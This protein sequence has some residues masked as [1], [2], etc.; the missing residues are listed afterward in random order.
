MYLLGQNGRD[1]F[2][3]HVDFLRLAEPRLGNEQLINLVPSSESRVG[4]EGDPSEL[5][6]REGELGLF[7]R[8]SERFPEIIGTSEERGR[9]SEV[10]HIAVG[11]GSEKRQV[12]QRR[13]ARETGKHFD[14][15]RKF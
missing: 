10:I 2:K 14:F 12:E 6:L 1:S 13:R 15:R 9:F 11:E 7:V 3:V 4:L 5:F 8:R